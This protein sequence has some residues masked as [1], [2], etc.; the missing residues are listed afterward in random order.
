MAPISP[1]PAQNPA[2][3][4]PL[5]WNSWDS[6]GL[7][8]DETDYRANTKVLAGLREFGWQYSVIDE[9]WYMQDPFAETV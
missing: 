7:T 6:Y 9:G 2:P 8:I 1:S 5:G 3:T 4:P